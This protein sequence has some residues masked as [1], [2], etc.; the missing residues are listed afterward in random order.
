VKLLLWKVCL[1]LLVGQI[2][3]RLETRTK[4]S[5]MC[6]SCFLPDKRDSA[7]KACKLQNSNSPMNS[8]THITEPERWWTIHDE[9]E[10]VGNSGGSSLRY[11]RANRSFELWIETKDQS[12]H[13]VAG[14]RRS[15]SQDSN[16]YTKVLYAVKRMM[17]YFLNLYIWENAVKLSMCM[18]TVRN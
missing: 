9:S 18:E 17:G 13:Q 8:I 11:W 5:D 10:A 1:A 12:N 16:F 7:V 2:Y 15:F 6:V 4:E 14:P 3:I